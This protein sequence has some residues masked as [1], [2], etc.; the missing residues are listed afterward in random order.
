MQSSSK[1]GAGNSSSNESVF[2][3]TN[4]GKEIKVSRKGRKVGWSHEENV[5]LWEAY[6]RS[7]ILSV[8]TGRGYTFLL[9]EIWDGKD[10]NLRS[11]ASL[12]VHV[13]RIKGKCYLSHQEKETIEK[14]VRAELGNITQVGGEVGLTDR[15]DGILKGT[16]K[17]MRQWLIVGGKPSRG[18]ISGWEMTGK[19]MRI[20]MLG[21]QQL[22]ERLLRK[23]KVQTMKRGRT[24]G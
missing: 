13:G 16:G 7:K 24:V 14:R 2:L 3:N 12:V 11:Q 18:K 6:I 23:G 21:D 8:R 15:K 1:D 4:S 9:K 20:G 22:L 17:G 10:F 5:F 19:T